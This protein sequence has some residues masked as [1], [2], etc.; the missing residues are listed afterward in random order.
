MQR[1]SL[2]CI[3]K[4]SSKNQFNLQR[5]VPCSCAYLD[6]TV[7][8]F[9]VVGET[10]PS[11]QPPAALVMEM[12]L[13]LEC[14]AVHLAMAHTLGI[15]IENDVVS[16]TL[17]LDQRLGQ[18]LALITLWM[19]RFSGECRNRYFLIY[20]DSGQW[21]L[22]DSLLHDAMVILH[23]FPRDERLERLH[24]YFQRYLTFKTR[25]FG[26]GAAAA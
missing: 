2:A 12:D 11:V 21:A 14:E 20:N 8:P 3:L 9:F 26:W 1:C 24:T 10:M 23:G 13:E 19:E 5:A 18:L 22:H 15:N 4:W 25:E 6:T 17:T 16:V 7:S